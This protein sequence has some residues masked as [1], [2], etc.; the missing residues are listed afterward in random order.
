[1]VTLI[2]MN[3]LIRPGHPGYRARSRAS[4]QVELLSPSTEF[5]SEEPYE[6]TTQPEL[7]DGKP[8][9]EEETLPL[10][11]TEHNTEPPQDPSSQDVKGSAQGPK[12]E[13]REPK[14]IWQDTW[15]LECLAMVFSAACFIAICV[16]LKVYDNQPRPMMSYDVSLNAIVSVL[17][18]ACKSCLA[19]VV[20]EAIGQLKWIWFQDAKTRQLLGMQAFDSASRGPLGS[21]VIIFSHRGRSLVSFGAAIVIV[22]LAFDP[23]FQQVLSYPVRNT[24]LGPSAGIATAPQA[25]DMSMNVNNDATATGSTLL[26]LWTSGFLVQPTCPSGNCTWSTFPSVGICSQCVDMTS[27]ATLHCRTPNGYNWTTLASHNSSVSGTCD[28]V[29]PNGPSST[30]SIRFSGQEGAPWMMIVAPY[31][32]TWQLLDSNAM[33]MPDTVLT[34]T[35]ANVTGPMAAYGYAELGYDQDRVSNASDPASGLFIKKATECSLAMCL[36]NYDISVENGN[37]VIKTTKLDYGTVYFN[38]AADFCFNVS[39]ESPEKAVT[40]SC[41]DNLVLFTEA[42]GDSIVNMESWRWAYWDNSTTNTSL[43]SYDFLDVPVNPIIPLLERIQTVTFETIMSNIAASLTKLALDNTDRTAN[44]IAYS[45]E[46]FV[47]V[48]WSWLILPALMVLFG[49]IFLT[50]T[51]IISKSVDAPLWKSSVLA[52]LYHGL[53]DLD[54][55]DLYQT[56]AEMERSAE[57]A[58]VQ[59][60]V[61]GQDERLML[62]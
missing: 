62:E 26:G 56:V 36:Q 45:S 12:K 10:N 6:Q 5:L 37:A 3:R 31:L 20:G 40:T 48:K 41:M 14:S 61:S 4:S 53:S 46:V 2:E 43:Q 54:D 59:L 44:G 38:H 11:H 33:A 50:V 58:H 18:T 21:L 23:F 60:R 32:V 35:F 29:F 34:Q 27:T 24:I 9:N 39:A 22:L 47:S 15:L 42:F 49:A 13:A 8:R 28:V 52:F 17:A 57:R 51:M 19:F 55:G 1:M 30:G 25:Y 16:L 7:D